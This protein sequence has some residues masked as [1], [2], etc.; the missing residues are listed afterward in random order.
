MASAVG[1]ATATAATSAR[2][3]CI[4]DAAARHAVNAVVL[5]A[6]GWHESRLRPDALARNRNGTWDVGAFQINTLHLALEA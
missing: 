2:A 5:R 4:D 6:I 1:V 3:D